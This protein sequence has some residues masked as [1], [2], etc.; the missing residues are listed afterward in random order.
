MIGRKL[1][2]R[3]AT[4]GGLGGRAVSSCTLVD[5]IEPDAPAIAGF[6]L[7]AR[8]GDLCADGLLESLLEESPDVIFHLA[9]VVSGEAEHDFD[10][11]YAVNM[12]ATRLL[13]ERIRAI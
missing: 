12:D 1:I 11:G 8:Q 4:A 10:K 3:I 7:T 2:S 5:V 6:A 9:G 13:F